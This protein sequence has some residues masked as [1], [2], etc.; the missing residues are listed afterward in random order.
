MLFIGTMRGLP[1]N[2]EFVGEEPVETER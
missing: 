1:L 2:A